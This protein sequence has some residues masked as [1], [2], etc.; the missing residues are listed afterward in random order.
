M[1]QEQ[2]RMNGSKAE[3][4]MVFD[5]KDLPCELF[6]AKLERLVNVG[7]HL[8]NRMLNALT[9]LA[10]LAKDGRLQ[11]TDYHGTILLSGPPGSGKSTLARMLPQLWAMKTG[12]QGKLVPINA[13]AI[14]SSDYGQSQ[15]NV[16]R[17]F[18]SLAE[19]SN[20]ALVFAIADELETLATN[21]EE[22]SAK[23]SPIDARNSVNAFLEQLDR[24][25]PNCLLL[26]TTN[27]PR[28]LDAAAVSRFDCHFHVDA[29]DGATRLKAL[30]K[31]VAL[32]NPQ[33]PALRGIPKA[34]AEQLKS[35]TEGFSFRDIS[36]LVLWCIVLHDLD[37]SLDGPQLVVA[38]K[39]VRKSLLRKGEST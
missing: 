10:Q 20:T 25:P 26:A 21:R 16:G 2:T 27:V 15:R 13:H 39:Y 12:A 28:L 22:I 8:F 36:S 4:K 14:P 30:G 6:Q 5:I 11:Q 17:L 9:L 37:M 3:P 34:L 24:K 23:T 18:D 35:L 19:L 7:S 38:A 29:P 33:S 1:L 31:V 32:I